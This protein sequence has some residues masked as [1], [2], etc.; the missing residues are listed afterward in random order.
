LNVADGICVVVEVAKVA[1]KDLNKDPNALAAIPMT[2]DPDDPNQNDDFGSNDNSQKGSSCESAVGV[3]TTLGKIVERLEDLVNVL[4]N[5][6]R[7]EAVINTTGKLDPPLGVVRLRVLEL[8]GMLVALENPV[9]DARLAA[10]KVLPA[11]LDMF[12]KYAWHNLLHNLV[13]KMLEPVI[14][15]EASAEGSVLKQS[16]LEDGRLLTRIIEAHADNDEH[17]KQPK[18]TRKGYMGQVKVLAIALVKSAQSDKLLRKHT[19]NAEWTEFLKAHEDITDD[20]KNDSTANAASPSHAL[21]LSRDQDFDL[22]SPDNFTDVPQMVDLVDDEE[23]LDMPEPV[24]LAAETPSSTASRDSPPEKA[25][26]PI[27]TSPDKKSPQKAKSTQKSPEKGKKG[28]AGVAAAA[29]GSASSVD[30][31][32]RV[33]ASVSLNLRFENGRAIASA[34]VGLKVA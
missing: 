8:I 17:V 1:S 15:A 33:V 16:L 2:P 34:Q 6:P 26:P 10:L 25:P 14:L 9:V 30:A 19:D 27:P 23:E 21:S 24:A 28:G 13:R 4:H 22:P 31:L 32:A 11:V 20:V 29:Q 5:P 12:F 3:G 7:M 18:A